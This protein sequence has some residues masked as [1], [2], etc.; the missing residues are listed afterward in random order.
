MQWGTFKYHM[1]LQRVCSNRQIAVIWGRRIGPNRHIAFI[2]AEKA[3]FT[4]PLVLF[5]VYVGGG[6]WLKTSYGG[7]G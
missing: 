4:I 3:Y 7:L 2:E 5:T 6:G 1:T